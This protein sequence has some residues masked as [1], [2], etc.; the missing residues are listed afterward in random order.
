MSRVELISNVYHYYYTALSLQHRGYLQRYI[1]G[2]S[3]QDGDAW[4]RRLGG[5]FRKLWTERRLQ[6]IPSSKIKRLWLHEIVQKA[7]PRLGGSPELANRICAELFAR[8]SAR[9]VHDCD[10]L[11]FVQ[12]V[13]W[14]AAAKMKR[15]GATII[16]DMREEHP[17]FQ[18]EILSEEAAQLGMDLP[19]PDAHYRHRVLEELALAD[20][21]FCPSSYAKRTFVSR[22]IS[23]NKLIVCPYGVDGEQFTS[24][25]TP[26]TRSEFRVLFLGRVCMRKGVHYLLEGFRKAALADARLILAGPVDPTFRVILKRYPG[27]F[28]ELGSIAHSRVQDCYLD[29]DVF[30]MPSL[31]DSYGLVVSEA[32]SAGLPV[33]VSENTGMSDFISD[34]REGFVVPIRDSEAIAERL[35]FLYE[36]RDRC[37]AMGAA[38]AA[39]ARTLDW[40][41]YQT[42]CANF[43]G[44]LFASPSPRG[45]TGSVVGGR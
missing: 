37:I 17:Q 18:A 15:R 6:D 10:A 34:G 5:T 25:K 40:N 35:T 14:V 13:G 8:K 26:P 39:T 1:T 30:V 3:A 44:S 42:V 32:M 43:Y 7:V 21:I 12:S 16:C 45:K 4:M 36:D 28:E 19:V 20:Y 27:L 24:S 29:A 41:N 31:A 23:D 2:P 33:I 9:L 38:G 22:G 11:H